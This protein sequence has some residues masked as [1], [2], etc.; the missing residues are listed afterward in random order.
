MPCYSSITETKMVNH[1]TLIAAM[2]E[3]GLDVDYA[4]DL[5]VGSRNGLSF[6]RNSSQATFQTTSNDDQL[7]GEVGRKYA[8][9]TTRQLLKRK[10]FTV[11]SFDEETGRMKAIQRG[12]TGGRKF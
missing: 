2:R 4:S 3:L 7:V 9:L 5:R 12:G 6:T 8:E 1:E 10:G 11:Q